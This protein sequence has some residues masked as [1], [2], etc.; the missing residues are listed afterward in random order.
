M[1]WI[2]S[3]IVFGRTWARWKVIAQTIGNFQARV[4]LSVFYFSVVPPF[5]LIVKL[6]K[7][8]LMLRPPQNNSLWVEHPAPELSWR[9]WRRQF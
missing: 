1:F 7:D 6:F 3:H 8:P 2:R 9:Q 5:A 4:L